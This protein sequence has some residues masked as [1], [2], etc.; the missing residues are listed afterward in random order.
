MQTRYQYLPFLMTS[1][2]FHPPVLRLLL[3][4]IFAIIA[5]NFVVLVIILLF[6]KIYIAIMQRYLWHADYADKADSRGFII[7]Y[8]LIRVNSCNPWISFFCLSRLNRNAA[9]WTHLVKIYTDKKTSANLWCCK[10]WHWCCKSTNY[11]NKNTNFT[12]FYKSQLKNHRKYFGTYSWKFGLSCFT[13]VIRGQRR[14]G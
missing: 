2:F 7:L 13:G 9:I 5:K 14:V 12:N 3:K 4:S 10:L 11:T 6:E 8:F 1:M